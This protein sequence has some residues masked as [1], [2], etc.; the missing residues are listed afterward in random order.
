VDQLDTGQRAPR[1]FGRRFDGP[2]NHN[3]TA[4]WHFDLHVWTRPVHR[5]VSWDAA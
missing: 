2:M 1:L 3:G 5:R 4:P